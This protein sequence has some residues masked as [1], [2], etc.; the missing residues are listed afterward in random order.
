MGIIFSE[1]RHW[2]DIHAYPRGTFP[3]AADGTSTYE[4]SRKYLPER[5]DLRVT[6]CQPYLMIEDQGD[7]VA[8][9]AHAFSMAY[10]CALRSV[11]ANDAFS[12]PQT[13]KLYHAAL[14]DSSDQKRGVSF[15]SLARH[16]R[17]H[18]RDTF[19][20]HK[21]QI[22][23]LPNERVD[24]KKT[25]VDGY[26]VIVGYQVNV[27][28][29]KFHKH[30]NVCKYHAYILPRFAIDPE[31][32]SA[33]TVLI[34]GYDDA[35]DSFIARNSWGSDWGVD[36]HFLIRYGDTEDEDFFTDI[37]VIRPEHESTF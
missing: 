17:N 14:A 10:Y 28:I 8:C 31:P 20:R 21:L 19:A 24:I 3:Y 22:F 29:E 35:V 32:I 16:L 9:V 5:F 15:S 36:G 30:P 23:H 7:S 6:H 25:L 34:V 33:H 27:D 11:D 13:D 26:P 2:D 12:Y 18:F 1:D 4:Q 37:V